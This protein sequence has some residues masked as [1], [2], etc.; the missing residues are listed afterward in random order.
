M[1]SVTLANTAGYSTTFDTLSPDNSNPAYFS[2]EN[3]TDYQ[4]FSQSG[5]GKKKKNKNRRRK[6]TQHGRRG[7]QSI[8]AK[9]MCSCMDML[10]STED[11]ECTLICKSGS[12]TKTRKLRFKGSK[13]SSVARSLLKSPKKK[14]T[15]KKKKKRRKRSKKAKMIPS[16][17]VRKIT[18]A[19]A[20]EGARQATEAIKRKAGEV[21]EAVADT[22]TDL[23]DKAFDAASSVL[24][25]MPVAPYQDAWGKS[26]QPGP[27]DAPEEKAPE[28]LEELRMPAGSPDKES[29]DMVEKPSL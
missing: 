19:F 23:K 8:I 10:G 17:P 12:K 22:A 25:K 21:G 28:G 20:K 14:Q 15:K 11:V 3:M 9:N 4:P 27:V 26:F 24:P 5:G 7:R 2:A 13:G 29:W 18:T 16:S 6:K 1:T